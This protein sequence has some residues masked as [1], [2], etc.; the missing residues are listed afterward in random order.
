MRIK[1]DQ[2]PRAWQVPR[3]QEGGGREGAAPGGAPGRLHA[4]LPASSL[5]PRS[6][7]PGRQAVRRQDVRPTR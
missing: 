3:K 2:A 6:L 4:A 5:T 1:H 7:T